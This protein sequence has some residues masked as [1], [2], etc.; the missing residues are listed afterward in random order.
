MKTGIRAVGAV[1]G[2]IRFMRY[3]GFIDEQPIRIEVWPVED[4]GETR[5]IVEFSIKCE[6]VETAV[7]LREGV[8]KELDEMGIL[9]RRD[10]TKT[11]MILDGLIDN[12]Y[13]F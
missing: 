1:A 3:S 8:I 9:I 5:Y 11:Q 6:D 4:D 7:T 13:S 10:A 2:P 12:G